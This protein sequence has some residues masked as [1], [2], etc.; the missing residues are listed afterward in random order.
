[1]HRANSVRHSNEQ[2]AAGQQ[3]RTGAPNA[4][5]QR[6]DFAHNDLQS[7]LRPQVDAD[8]V[9]TADN[10]GRKGEAKVQQVYV[11]SCL[12]DGDFGEILIKVEDNHEGPSEPNQGFNSGQHL[13]VDTDRVAIDANAIE[14][15]RRRS[16]CSDVDCGPRMRLLEDKQY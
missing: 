12:S 13:I 1:M 4:H 11:K 9:L 15:N 16:S 6:S 14:Q 3:A 7:N 2:A 10:R 5:D 8:K